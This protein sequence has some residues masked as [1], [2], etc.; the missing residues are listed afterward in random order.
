M[1]GCH[2][3]R[4][5]EKQVLAMAGHSPCYPLATKGL[6]RMSPEPQSDRRTGVGREGAGREVELEGVVVGECSG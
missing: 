5:R 3:R 2:L 6:Y 4:R 1:R